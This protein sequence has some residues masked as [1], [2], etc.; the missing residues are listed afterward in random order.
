MSKP[1]RISRC[2]EWFDL[3][4]TGLRAHEIIRAAGW[5]SG[6]FGVI[7]LALPRLL[8]IPFR[9]GTLFP[10]E[11]TLIWDVPLDEVEIPRE[12]EELGFQPIRAIELPEFT[13]ENVTC[14]LGD[15]DRSTFCE[16]VFV[17][18]PNGETGQGISFSSY[19][20]GEPLTRIKTFMDWKVSPLDQPPEFMNQCV[21]GS[22]SN[23]YEAHRSWL[24][25]IPMKVVPTTYENFVQRNCIDHARLR[26]L[27]VQRRVWIE[28]REEDVDR[29]LRKKRLRIEEVEPA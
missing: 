18:M 23:A 11:V 5:G 12:L 16:L 29:L 2:P 19:F 4:M 10:S 28:A 15:Q 13:G 27:Y 24:A 17:R 26:D 25:T 3:N 20:E 9:T 6:I 22:L 1:N 8:G 14:I 21:P 7:I